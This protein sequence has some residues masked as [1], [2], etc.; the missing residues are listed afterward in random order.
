MSK[1]KVIT[2]KQEEKSL[3]YNRFVAPANGTT[4]EALH[5]VEYCEALG[6]NP[7][8]GDVIFQKFETKQ[9]PRTTFVTTRDGLMRVAVRDENYVGP[10]I[11]NVVREGDQFEF[12]PA[13]GS[14]IHKFG[15]KR[16]RILG[17]YAVLYHKQYRP[18]ACWAD[19]AEYF[20]ANAKSQNGRSYIWDQ[21]PSIMIE[22]VAESFALKRQFPIVGGLTTEEEMGLD[23]NITVQ[24]D[25][26]DPP[27]P[28]ANQVK[29][30]T[31]SEPISIQKEPEPEV[32]KT[33]AAVDHK[34]QLESVLDDRPRE[35]KE[36]PM[37]SYQPSQTE[38]D[39]SEQLYRPVVQKANG[40]EVE[41]DRVDIGTSNS[42]IPFAKVFIIK[43]SGQ[44]LMLLAKGEE[45]VAIAKTLNQGDVVSIEIMEEN[46]FHFLKGV[47][48]HA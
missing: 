26:Q 41:I 34:N 43:N 30:Q 32:E 28:P 20:S 42:G 21:Y 14:V 48:A 38:N 33:S 4:D 11:S 47:N 24:I 46:G 9:G 18:Y 22:K 5:F 27:E 13:E 45:H 10:P 16:G 37:R 2:F 6:L 1:E 31:I 3:I 7:L 8:L 19:F 39:Q 15:Q 35:I 25:M 44:K 23:H 17:A 12:L 29:Q 40:E 36:F